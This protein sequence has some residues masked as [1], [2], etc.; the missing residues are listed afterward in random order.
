VFEAVTKAFASAPEAG[1]SITIVSF[2]EITFTI[3]APTG[4]VS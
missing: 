2:I 4:I 1:S 3:V